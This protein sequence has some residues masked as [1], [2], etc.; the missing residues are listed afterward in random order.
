VFFCPVSLAT[1][2]TGMTFSYLLYLEKDVSYK[3]IGIFL[4]FV[5]IMQLI[6]FLLWTHQ[7][8]DIYNKTISFIGMILNYCQ[9]IVLGILLLYF[10]KNMP[11]DNNKLI[12][13]I[14]II[15]TISAVLYM[16]QFIYEKNKCSFKKDHP[17]LLWNWAQLK[18]NEII[19]V[20]HV[21]TMILLIAIGLPN[22]MTALVVILLGSTA[23]ITSYINYPRPFVGAIWCLFT[24]FIPMIIYFYKQLFI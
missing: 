11:K 1:F 12:K 17:Y 15:Y 21:F 23:L 16:L 14:L 8:C 3:I 4:G 18:N 24:A 13:I 9:P 7:V 6:E 5:V 2:I 10:Y 19:D 22:K 20:L